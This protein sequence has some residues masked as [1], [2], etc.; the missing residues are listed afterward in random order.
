MDTV[1][2]RPQEA[3]EALVTINHNI[4]AQIYSSSC[5]KPLT[6]KFN[7]IVRHIETLF[8]IFKNSSQAVNLIIVERNFRVK[9]RSS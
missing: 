2:D 6:L 3:I 7:R 9:M 8:L 5:L 1:N 4:N